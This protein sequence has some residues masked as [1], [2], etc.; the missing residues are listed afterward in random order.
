MD[1]RDKL[2]HWRDWH[3]NALEDIME[4]FGWDYYEMLW[5]A[6]AEGLDKA[7]SGEE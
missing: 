2:S 5:I 6:W 1:I 3:E 4:W 7:R